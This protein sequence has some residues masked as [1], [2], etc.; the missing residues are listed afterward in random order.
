MS[1]Y[2]SVD[3]LD[4]RR[5]LCDNMAESEWWIDKVNKQAEKD[6][7]SHTESKQITF[8]GIEENGAFQGTGW[9]K[10]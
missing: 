6:M 10:D 7:V 5:K 4:T 9:E 1:V 8:R 3:I 2:T